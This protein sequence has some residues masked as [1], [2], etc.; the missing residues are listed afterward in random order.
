MGHQSQVTISWCRVLALITDYHVRMP[1]S[2]TKHR[3]PCQGDGSRYQ[4]QDTLSSF[5]MKATI[6]GYHLRLPESGTNHRITSQDAEFRHQSQP[7]MSG[8]GV[9]APITGHQTAG[10]AVGTSQSNLKKRAVVD[11]VRSIRLGQFRSSGLR[12]LRY[13]RLGQVGLVN[14]FR[15]YLVG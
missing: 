2:G 10:I 13:V 1:A 14:K 4:S 8:C 5:R 15:S 3:A 12:Q 6:T 9:Q 11:Q 7:S